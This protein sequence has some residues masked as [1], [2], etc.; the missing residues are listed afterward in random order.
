MTPALPQRLA[1]ASAEIDRACQ[2]L[3]DP[4]SRHLDQSSAVLGAVVAEVTA[5][6]DAIRAARPRPAG[7]DQALRLAQSVRRA[8]VLLEGAARFHADWIRCLG[9]LCAGYTDRGEPSVVSHPPRV[10]AR[11]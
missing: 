1:A 9:A 4:T 7:R 8:R 11:G 5:C 10:W 6:R 3:L 2:I